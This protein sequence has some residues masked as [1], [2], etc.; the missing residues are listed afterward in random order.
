[1][2][3]FQNLSRRSRAVFLALIVI[4]GAA[5][6]WSKGFIGLADVQAQ[7]KELTASTATDQPGSGKLADSPI[8]DLTEKQAGTLKIAPVGPRDFVIAK[9]AVGTIDF[10]ENLLV[11]VFSQYPGKILKAFYNLGDEVKQGDVLFTIDSPDLLQAESNLLASSGV[12]EL[13]KRTLARVTMLLKTGGSA[14]KDVDQ[15]T[16][17]EQTA[18]GNFKAAR[19]AVRIFGK[20][21]DEVDQILAQRKVDSTLLVPSPISGKIVTRNAAPGFLTQPGT[22]PAPFQVADLSTM[23]ML[24]N[25]IETDVPAYKVGQE[26]EVKVPAYPGKVFKGH[27][28]TVGSMIDPNTRRQL[29]R[30]EI[31]DPDHLLRSGMYASFVI[32]VGDPVSSLAVPAEGVVREGDGTMTVW[33]TGDSRRFT[34]RTVKTGLQQ[35]GWTQIVEGLQPGETV[36]TDGAVFLSNKLLLGDAG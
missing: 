31:D 35:D 1:V 32:R 36:V 34:K 18:E 6:L 3:V 21:D 16:S 4:G 24:A 20:T 19:N 2:N 29:V 7:R 11:Q 9:T 30:S 26:V 13:Q 25:V 28:T 12:L 10:N 33:I 23:W 22:P 17:D 14:Q 8:V 27:V 15:S 5:L